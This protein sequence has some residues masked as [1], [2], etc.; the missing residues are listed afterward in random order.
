M[1]DV[2][3]EQLKTFDVVIG[4]EGPTGEVY[5]RGYYCQAPNAEYAELKLGLAAEK[6]AEETGQRVW[7]VSISEIGDE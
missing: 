1:A 2:V 7:V 3:K 6:A 5:N 4:F